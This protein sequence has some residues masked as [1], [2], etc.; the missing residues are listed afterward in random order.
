MKVKVSVTLEQVGGWELRK[1]T[2]TG[3]WYVG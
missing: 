1:V 3:M 2:T